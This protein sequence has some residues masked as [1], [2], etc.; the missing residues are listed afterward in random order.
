MYGIGGIGSIAPKNKQLIG[1]MG[2]H[3][4]FRDRIHLRVEIS[5]DRRRGFLNQVWSAFPSDAY[6]E[7]LLRGNN[8]AERIG[9][10]TLTICVETVHKTILIIV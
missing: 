1:A 8:G 6:R 5:H 3:N 9:V 7:G 10:K 4:N 2:L